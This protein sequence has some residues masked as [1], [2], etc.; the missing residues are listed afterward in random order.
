MGLQIIV[1]AQAQGQAQ[2]QILALLLV[3]DGWTLRDLVRRGKGRS[4]SAAQ[5]GMPALLRAEVDTDMDLEGA[6]RAMLQSTTVVMAL[7]VAAT[8]AMP[9]RATARRQHY[10]KSGMRKR[11][12]ARGLR[13]WIGRGVRIQRKC[14][15][16]SGVS[17]SLY[18]V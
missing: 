2:A 16:P 5:Q 3:L 10:S 1:K 12:I 15:F 9:K 6:A 7:A 4:V 8:M 18:L 11:G 17:S 13:R 14:E